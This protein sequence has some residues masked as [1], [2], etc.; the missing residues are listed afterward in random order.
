M[1]P[2][3]AID[4]I[5]EQI[6]GFM[7]PFYLAAAGGDAGLAREAIAELVDAYDCATAAELEP[8]VGRILGFSTVAMD[9]LRLSMKPECGMRRSCGIA[10]MRLRSAG[11]ASSAARYWR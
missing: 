3:N 10:R 4:C 1:S 5:F 11:R 9:N 7:L 8:L 6:L 2:P